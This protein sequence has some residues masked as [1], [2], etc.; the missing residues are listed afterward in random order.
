V[1]ADVAAQVASGEGRVF[2]LMIE[3]QLVAGRQELVSGQELTYGQSITDGCAG[4]EDTL[5]MLDTLAE[6]VRQRRSSP[7]GSNLILAAA[8]AK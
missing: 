3:S 2:G 5:E 8:A 4:Y 7:S 6:A 1:V